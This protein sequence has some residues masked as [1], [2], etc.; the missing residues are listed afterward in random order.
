MASVPSACVR[1]VSR[2]L[3]ARDAT[4]VAPWLLNKVLVVGGCW[5]RIVEVE[6]YRSDEPAS[7]T[8]RGRTPRNSVMFGPAGHLYVYF[9][10][11][12]HHCANVVTGAAGEGQAV[13]VRAIT[14]VAGLEEMRSRRPPGTAEAR[15]TDG[16]GKLCQALGL[17]LADSGRDVCG[18]GPVQLCDDGMPPPERP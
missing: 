13:L 9:S 10:Y 16:P 3:V 15:L 11:G 8:F 7:H 1:V 18:D 4:E 14:P 2:A 5:G 17:T 12:M 6:A